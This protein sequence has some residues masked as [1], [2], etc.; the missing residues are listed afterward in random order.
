MDGACIHEV[1]AFVQQTG[2]LTQ[3][4]GQA[5]RM[6]LIEELKRRNV[7]RVVLAYLVL[8]WLVLQVAD[9]LVDAL[10]LPVIWS[11]A[12]VALLLI[13]FIPAVVFSWVYE[14]TPEGLKKESDISA[15]QS[16][17]GHTAKKLN[18]AIVFLLLVAISLFVYDRFIAKSIPSGT[19][20]EPVDAAVLSNGE[21]R[22]SVAV[23]AFQNMSADADNEY[24]ADGISE[25][26]LNLLADVSGLSVASRTS[27]FA[28]KG[29]DTPIP[30]IASTLK[31]RYVLEGSVRKA[32]E[33]VRVTAQ[34]IDAQTDRHLWSE[35]FDRALRDV[36]TIQDEIAGAI[37]DALE[38]E[39]LGEGGTEVRSELIDPEIYN[40]FLEA[41][42]LLRK[43]NNEDVDAGNWLLID[44]VAAEPRFA[45]AH[46][47]LA[48][49]YTLN[50]TLRDLV[51]REFLNKLANM[52]A[53]LAREVDPTLGGIDMIQGNIAQTNFDYLTALRHYQRSI[54]LEPAEARPYHWR[55][56]LYNTLGYG[57]RCRD[58]LERALELDPQNPNVHFALASCLLVEGGWDRAVEL[59][60]H[61]ATLGNAGGYSLAIRARAQQGDLEEALR[62][63][64]YFR[65]QF[66]SATDE[67]DDEFSFDLLADL[68]SGQLAE[69]DLTDEQLEQLN[70]AD[71]LYLNSPEPAL[72]L[73]AARDEPLPNLAVV[74]A[75]WGAGYRS[76]HQDPRF[77]DFL[78]LQ[79]VLDVWREL[80]PPKG[81]RAEG[82]T[83][84][85]AGE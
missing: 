28:F 83:F 19:P 72:Q 64:R 73:L 84:T 10:E 30:E 56:L 26:I 66:P 42:F 24:F 62:H 23:L 78:A 75:I 11:K 14:L 22:P 76:L 34:L 49:A 6:N 68:F 69:Q 52:H 51:G 17:T 25:E 45:R 38:V 47:L 41:R 18:H 61:G 79:G 27:A 44:V 74:G 39:L 13:G 55:G 1:L 71:R 32:G 58:D 9:V 43:R 60:T 54:E 21:E 63:L 50:S 48:E 12:V 59:A 81:C 20:A 5:S 85:C 33:Q 35:T 82:D 53:S 29:T 77:I 70:L 46:V 16:I 65:E 7:F 37:G 8:G 31:V 80:G 57:E 36:F 40:Q 15:D 4:Q 67:E 2:T 3:S